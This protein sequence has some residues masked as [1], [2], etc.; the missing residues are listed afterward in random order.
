MLSITIADIVHPQYDLRYREWQKWRFTYLGG[1]DFKIRYLKPF[2]GRESQPDYDNRLDI[3][4][5][6]AQLGHLISNN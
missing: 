3:S 6:P 1:L 2:S 4:P 5:V